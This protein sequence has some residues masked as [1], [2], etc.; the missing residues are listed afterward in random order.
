MRAFSLLAA[1]IPCGAAPAPVYDGQVRDEGNGLHS[2]YM[3]VPQGGKDNHAATIEM[4]PD[5]SLVSAWF[6]G[7]HEEASGEAIAVSRLAHGSDVWTNPIIV[8]KEDK[9]TNQNPLLFFDST[10]KI[11]HLF[12]THGNADAGESE[13]EVFHLSSKDGGVTWSTPANY[14]HKKGIFIRNRIIRRKDGTLFWPYYSTAHGLCP[15]FS[16]SNSST[17]PESGEGWTTKLM[18]EGKATLEQPTCWR[19]PHK[20]GTIECYFR[21]FHHQSIYHSESND[22]GENFTIPQKT[23]LPNPGSGIEAYPLKNGDIALAY[24]PTTVGRDP[25][26][27]GISSDDGK[28]WKSRKIQDG[29][30]GTPSTGHNEFSYPTIIQTPDGLI[31]IMYSYAPNGLQRTMKYVRLAEDWITNHPDNDVVVV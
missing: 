4:L 21:D 5:G 13:A 12:H 27:V 28:T 9:K 29:P 19:Q 25:L 20:N 23:Q 6:T 24:N 15:E 26:S 8:S 31:H 30:S 11:L 17:V 10:T 14:L 22:E 3:I 16:W 2:A 7:A 18:N 1:A